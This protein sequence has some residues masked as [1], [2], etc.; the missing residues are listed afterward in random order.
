[1]SE[2]RTHGLGLASIQDKYQWLAYCLCGWVA[3]SYCKEPM[4]AKAEW[5]HHMSIVKGLKD[6]AGCGTCAQCVDAGVQM[7]VCSKCGNKRCPRA[8]NHEHVCSGSNDP[9]NAANKAAFHFY[10]LEEVGK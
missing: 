3:P 1:M 10:L 4:F 6:A 9:E 2:E 8:Y 7:A 5:D